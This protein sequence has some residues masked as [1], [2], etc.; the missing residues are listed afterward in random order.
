MGGT[1]AWPKFQV[2]MPNTSLSV[3]QVKIGREAWLG[4]GVFGHQNDLIPG[5]TEL[6]PHQGFHAGNVFKKIPCRTRSLP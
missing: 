4:T 6:P 2:K 3:Q 1:E 5:N